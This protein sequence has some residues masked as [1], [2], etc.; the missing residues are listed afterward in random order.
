MKFNSQGDAEVT[1]DAI[2]VGTGISGGWAAKEL[3]EKGL[4]TLVLEKGRMVKHGD[5]P[6]ANLDTWDLE[7]NNNVPA[8]EIQEHYM[9]QN[10][11]GYTVRPQSKHWFVKD[12]EH[13]YGEKERFDWMRGYHVGG[14]SIMWGR[15]SYRWSG[16]R[17][18]GER[19]GRHC[20]GMARRLLRHLSLVRLRGKL[21]RHQRRIAGPVATT[22]RQ[23]SAHDA[24]QLRRRQVP[25]GRG[26]KHGRTGGH[27]R[28]G[29][30]PYR[31]RSRPPPRVPA[32]LAN[33]VTAASGV[34]LTAATSAA[35]PPPFRWPR[36]PAT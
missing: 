16:P 13:P 15:H 28:P 11:T 5:Y 6:T 3:C 36:R 17:F 25:Q 27:R 10:R 18:S 8:E 31:L 9:K 2:V 19:E 34:V 1:Y 26:R 14:R 21:R 29:R 23:V 33:S 4:K 7:L 22:R 30:S 24:A 20:H 35:S 12:D 32:V